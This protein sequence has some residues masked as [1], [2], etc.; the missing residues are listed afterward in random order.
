MVKAVLLAYANYVVAW[1]AWQEVY[2]NT[3]VLIT[4]H[5]DVMFHVP[6]MSN[7]SLSAITDFLSAYWE[8][9]AATQGFK[10]V[11]LAGFLLI[12]IASSALSS[13]TKWL[14]EAENH[15]NDTI[16]IELLLKFVQMRCQILQYSVS[17][18]VPTP[19]K[20]NTSIPYKNK[21]ASLATINE[22]IY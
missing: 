19:I 13:T 5:L 9:H 15:S 20:T 3:W 7:E 14:F 11:D 8:N 17:T 12:Y 2:N 1:K 18:Q 22:L 10:I 6:T 4:K 16:D 21:A